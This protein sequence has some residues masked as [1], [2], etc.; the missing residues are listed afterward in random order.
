MACLLMMALQFA[1]STSASVSKPR[2]SEYSRYKNLGLSVIESTTQLI[3][4]FLCY[5]CSRAFSSEH[6][7]EMY[8]KMVHTAEKIHQRFGGHAVSFVGSGIK[9]AEKASII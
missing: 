9:T 6:G 1:G 5:T 2:D 8:I 3:S 4:A 7:L